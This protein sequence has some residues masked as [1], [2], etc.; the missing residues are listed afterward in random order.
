MKFVMMMIS[1]VMLMG[2]SSVAFATEA[3][4]VEAPAAATAD[5]KDAAATTD[6]KKKEEEKKEEGSDE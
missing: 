4:K 5:K 3:A 6:E 1:A 2:V